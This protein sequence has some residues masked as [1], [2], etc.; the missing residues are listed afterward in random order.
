MKGAARGQTSLSRFYLLEEERKCERER[1][2]EMNRV[3]I[4]KER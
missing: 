4:N 3:E 2:R 1:E